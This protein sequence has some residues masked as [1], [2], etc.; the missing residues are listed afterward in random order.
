LT[1]ALGQAA[2][3]AAPPASGG[4]LPGSRPG[5]HQAWF[6]SGSNWR[7]STAEGG[8][9]VTLKNDQSMWGR[10]RPHG[11][12]GQHAA[13]RIARKVCPRLMEPRRAAARTAAVPSTRPGGLRP[14][15]RIASRH[16]AKDAPPAWASLRSVRGRGSR[17]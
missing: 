5:S 4:D 14:P 1:A 17:R 9:E 15:T 3:P 8:S 2:A 7:P 12:A 16:A 13:K 10:R 6:T 11:G